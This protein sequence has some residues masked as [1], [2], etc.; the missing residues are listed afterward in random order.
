MSVNAK[1]VKKI[2]SQPLFKIF[3][4]YFV[5]Q[6]LS[7][8]NAINISEYLIRFK[9][10]LFIF[11]FMMVLWNEIDSIKR[12]FFVIK[13]LFYSSVLSLLFEAVTYFQL[14]PFSRTIMSLLT[15][16]A[17]RGV[18]TDSIK[19]RYFINIFDNTL[20]PLGFITLQLLK[21]TLNKVVIFILIFLIVFFAAVSDFRGQFAIALVALFVSILIVKKRAAQGLVLLGVFLLLLLTIN[22]LKYISVNSINRIVDPSPAD[23]ETIEGRIFYWKKAMDIGKA[24]PMFGVGLGNFYEYINNIALR[25]STS[26]ENLLNTWTHPHNVFFATLAESGVI[27]LVSYSIIIIYFF[28]Y[29]LINFKNKPYQIKLLVVAF[30]CLFSYSLIYPAV[31]IT[32]GVLF[33]SLRVLILKLNHFSVSQNDRSS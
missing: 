31:K 17:Y 14:Q 29:D 6:A 28:F 26:P 25:K 9:D 18:I 3:L 7:I 33:W 12:I 5:T 15:D 10:L 11:M 22:S 30:W 32:Y 13:I 27:G 23:Y 4:V 16:N 24:F 8:L 19:N 20:I 21:K 2:I 1:L